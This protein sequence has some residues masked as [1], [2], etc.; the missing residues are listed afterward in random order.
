M[1]FI[2][3]RAIG[4]G[5]AQLCGERDVRQNKLLASYGE[6]HQDDVTQLDF[7]PSQPNVLL[8][9]SMDGLVCAY[10]F[11]QTLDEDEILTTVMNTG[12]SVHKMGYF[13]PDGAFVYYM[14]HMETFKLY[15]SAEVR[16]HIYLRGEL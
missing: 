11:S 13:G 4:R 16:C 7:H 12:A 15:H 3:E 6:C 14:S 8:S 9:G 5:Q 1:V 2:S 10:D